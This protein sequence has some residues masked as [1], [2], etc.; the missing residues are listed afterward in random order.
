M[1]LCVPYVVFLF[2]YVL[3]FFIFIHQWF[4]VFIKNL[5]GPSFNEWSQ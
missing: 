1:Q 4:E 2:Q 3:W 5:N